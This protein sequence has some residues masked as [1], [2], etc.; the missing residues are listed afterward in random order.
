VGQSIREIMADGGLVS[1]ELMNVLV[2]QRIS[3][4]DCQRGFILD[5][6]PRSMVQAEDFQTTLNGLGDRAR[7]IVFDIDPEN[8]V[9]RLTARR[10]CA[11]C[12]RVYN[13]LSCPPAKAEY[14]DDDGTRLV[15]RTDDEENVIRKRFAAYE[16]STAPLLS[17]YEAEGMIR[18][19]AGADP[20]SVA[21]QIEARL[22]D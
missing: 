22:R 19:D 8:L 6:Y 20:H 7:V 3:A 17:Y 21:R 15:K 1:D 11:V 2:A 12:G 10:S 16:T 5:G 18:V 14:C 4:P 13:L 9:G